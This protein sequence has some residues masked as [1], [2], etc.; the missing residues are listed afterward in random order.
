M[1]WTLLLAVAAVLFFGFLGWGAR[2]LRANQRV[3]ADRLGGLELAAI[4][5][6]AAECRTVV[7]ERAGVDL[8]PRDP[9]AAARALD[10]L[11][12]DGRARAFFKTPEYEFRF[13]EVVG[14]YLGELIRRHADAEWV[15]DPADPVLALR[16]GGERGEVRPAHLAVHHQN[17][18]TPG[19]L[20]REIVR[21][22]RG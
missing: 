14:A 11:V 1:S 22:L 3:L 17:H 6:L 5:R 10:E 12:L 16:R 8:D 9:D 4:P 20:H 13:A 19:D 2:L 15:P 18:G 7:R 21:I